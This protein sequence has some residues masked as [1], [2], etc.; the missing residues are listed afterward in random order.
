ML[1]I[2]WRSP[3]NSIVSAA[4]VSIL[5]IGCT[6]G[7][8]GPRVG[9]DIP[10]S[11]MQVSGTVA[12]SST[13][14]GFVGG[15]TIEGMFRENWAIRVDLQARTLSSEVLINSTYSITQPEITVTGTL[16]THLLFLDIPV[17]LSYQPFRDR[18]VNPFVCAGIML[19]LPTHL[20]MHVDLSQSSMINGAPIIYHLSDQISRYEL[21][22]VYPPWS[23]LVLTGGMRITLSD[24]WEIN[25]EARFQQL[26]SDGYIATVGNNVYGDPRPFHVSQSAPK[27]AMGIVAGILLRL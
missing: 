13:N 16:Q 17:Q 21:E 11:G 22:H 23:S 3:L 18:T 12:S 14:V 27:F 7:R 9:V 6:S 5:L 2:S 25:T 26:I 8:V 20:N 1:F 19:S 24:K 4:L 15:A 10:L